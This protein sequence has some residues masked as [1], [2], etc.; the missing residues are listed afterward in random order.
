LEILVSLTW[1][2]VSQLR[3]TNVLAG[4][5]NEGTWKMGKEENV[6]ELKS[7]KFCF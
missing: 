3:N 4:A 7:D 5:T 2:A 1:V 6:M